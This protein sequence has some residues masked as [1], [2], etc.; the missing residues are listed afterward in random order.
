MKKDM[1][2]LPPDVQAQVRALEALPDDEIDTTDA[3]EILD[4]S[5]ARRGGLLPACEATDY[6]QA[7]RGHHRV[8][9]SSCSRRSRIPN[10]HKWGA[11]RS[12]P[13]GRWFPK[14]ARCAHRNRSYVPGPNLKRSRGTS[15]PLASK[16]VSRSPLGLGSFGENKPRIY[17]WL[18][19]PVGHGAGR[20]WTAE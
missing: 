8:V 20:I 3:P 16:R 4:W 13:P 10:G 6:D 19:A 17:K 14:I 12:R 11:P 1:T 5:D 9:Q 2:E 18:F 15:R 7:R